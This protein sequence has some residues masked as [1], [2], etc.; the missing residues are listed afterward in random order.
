MAAALLL[1][2]ILDM[3]P[4]PLAANERMAR[5]MFSTPPQPVSMSTSTGS[6]VMS[7]IRRTS[8]STS[9]IVVIPRSAMPH[10]LAATPPP[11]TYS[12]LEPRGFG[13]PAA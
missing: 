3:R 2:L 7:V 8:L 4:R 9:S 12:R 13:K 11:E 5:E 10:E 6:G 1:H